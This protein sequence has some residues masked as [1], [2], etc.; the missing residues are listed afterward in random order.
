MN[1]C[2]YVWMCTS[3]VQFW[4]RIPQDQVLSTK[5][6]YL[7]QRDTG[8][9]IEDREKGEGNKG[10]G[11]GVFVP[12]ETDVAHRQLVVYKGKEGDSVIG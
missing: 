1:I 5:D 7:P 8:W 4:L 12:R 11:Q 6:F 10:D 2:L 3:C 9:E